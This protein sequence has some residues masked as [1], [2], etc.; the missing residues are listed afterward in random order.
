MGDA[1]KLRQVNDRLKKGEGWVGYRYSNNDAG[2]EV[3]SK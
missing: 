3:A 2:A 1:A